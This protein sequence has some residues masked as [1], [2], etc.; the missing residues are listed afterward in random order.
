MDEQG[1]KDLRNG[2]ANSQTQ[3][4]AAEE[5]ERLREQVKWLE[6]SRQEIMLDCQA[7][8]GWAADR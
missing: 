1:L 7:E 5:I 4:D 6:N 2:M 8:E 3:H